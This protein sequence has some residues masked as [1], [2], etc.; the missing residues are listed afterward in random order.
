MPYFPDG[1]SRPARLTDNGP[2]V[3]LF[4]ALTEPEWYNL[5]GEE[6]WKK[7]GLGATRELEVTY[8]VEAR[9]LDIELAI[10]LGV[11]AEDLLPTLVATRQFL[12]ERLDGCLDVLQ[13]GGEARNIKVA[14]VMQEILR[15]RRL[16]RSGE[17]ERSL[18]RC[19]YAFEKSP[20]PVSSS[21]LLRACWPPT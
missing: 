7:Q 5:F 12:Q 14:R 11:R 19:S 3:S 17:R 4:E 9:L 6:N 16:R 21:S 2:G 10:G 20:K 8:T 13:A 18:P 15:E 1:N